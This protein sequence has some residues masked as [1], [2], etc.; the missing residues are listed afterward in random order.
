M[1]VQAYIGVTSALIILVGGLMIVFIY[2]GQMRSE[3][4]VAL[5]LFVAFYFL[6]RMAQSVQAIRKNRMKTKQGLKYLI[7]E[8]EEDDG[9]PKSP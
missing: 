1:N 4:R 9:R 3:F 6:V 5:G 7:E 8:P 2:P